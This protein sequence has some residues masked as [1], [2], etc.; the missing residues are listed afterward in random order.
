MKLYATRMQI[1]EA[2]RDI[3]NAKLGMSHEFANSRSHERFDIQLLI[4]TLNLYI[5]WCICHSA[6]E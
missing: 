5:L 6:L 3:N 1:E 4:G 2:F